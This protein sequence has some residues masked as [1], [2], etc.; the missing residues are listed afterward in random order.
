MMFFKKSYIPHTIKNEVSGVRITIS[1]FV[2]NGAFDMEI[3]NSLQIC[4]S[5]LRPV[6]PES[7]S[8]LI[9]EIYS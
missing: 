3:I 7:D 2:M 1:H 5:A 4:N 8:A 9:V 6:P